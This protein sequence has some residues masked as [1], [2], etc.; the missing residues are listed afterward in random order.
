[1]YS[2]NKPVSQLRTK[3]R[4]EFERHRFVSQLPV[5]DVLLHHSHAE[6]QVCVHIF[7]LVTGMV[8]MVAV[9]CGLYGYVG[10]VEIVP[11]NRAMEKLWDGGSFHGCIGLG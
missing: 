8:I 1:M 10:I 3:M 5:V 9:I 6:Y 4:T 7:S 11:R 2:L